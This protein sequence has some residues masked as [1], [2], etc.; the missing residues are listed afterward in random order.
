MLVG[1]IAVPFIVSSTLQIAT[2]VFGIGASRI[3]PGT[4][5][6]PKQT[7][8]TGII[9]LEAALDR[10]SARLLANPEDGNG[11]GAGRDLPPEWG[12]ADAVHR[13]CDAVEGG[14]QAWAALERLLIGQRQLARH[15]RDDL[16]PLRRDVSA[17]LPAELR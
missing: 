2:A 10:A 8:S 13:A 14:T 12:R 1:A 17:H 11:D 16:M 15:A 4:P 9:E 3:P 7:C 5:G 6:S